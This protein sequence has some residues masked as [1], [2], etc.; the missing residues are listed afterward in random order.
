MINDEHRTV[1][2]ADSQLHVAQVST[3]STKDCRVT[4]APSIEA[5]H[6]HALVS[7]INP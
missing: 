1:L 7:G 3:G 5:S 4:P 6:H 2:L